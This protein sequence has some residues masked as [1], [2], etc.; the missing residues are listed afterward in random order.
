M[1][2]DEELADRM[3]AMLDGRDPVEKK[4]FGGLGFIVDG[5]MAIAA[6]SQ[7]GALV[8]VDRDEADDLCNQPGVAPMV[9]KGRPMKGWLRVD[10]EQLDEDQDLRA[11]IDRGLAAAAAAD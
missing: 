10:L 2:Y 7:G 3:R 4:M 8:R 5:K 1:A 11:W 9:M 6:S